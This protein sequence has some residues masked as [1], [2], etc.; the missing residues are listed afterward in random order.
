M[1]ITGKFFRIWKRSAILVLELVMSYKVGFFLLLASLFLGNILIPVVSV[2]IYA[3][4]AG[5][6]GWSLA[7]F[8]LF[9]GTL[10]LVIGLWHTFFA[11]LLGET[12][13]AVKEGT[14]DKILLRPFSSLGFLTA[15]SFDPD[16]F[17]EIAAGIAI[18]AWALIQLKLFNLMLLPYLFIVFLGAFFEYALTIIAAALSFIF[19]KTWRLFELITLVERFSRYPISIYGAGMRIFLTF[20][21]PAAIASYYPASVLLGK[22]P[23]ITVA[24]IALPVFA[25]F[26]F[27]L[28][29]WHFALRHYTSAGG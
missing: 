9:Q 18:V 27:S 21:V 19:V 22:Q 11:S 15:S 20:I 26:A 25:F 10:I 12:I 14:F 3:V 23:I 13:G 2:I 5:I 8:V 16:G 4:S 6:P 1:T 29:L 28:W 7:E 17:A 24:W